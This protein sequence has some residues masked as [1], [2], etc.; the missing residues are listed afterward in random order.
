MRYTESMQCPLHDG[1][2]I[3][4][5]AQGE[6]GLT[7]SY[8]TCP[9][10]RGYWMDS[11]A[12]NFIKL[13]NVDGTATITTASTYYCPVCTK[14]LIWTTGE[15]IPDGVCVY[16]CPVH[17]G[18][19]FPTGQLAAFKKAQQTKIEYHK[20]WHIPMPNVASILLGGLVLILLSGGLAVTLRGLE[21][22]QTMESQAKQILVNHAVYSTADHT[23]ILITATTGLDA[24]A[25]VHVPALNNLT[26]P[27]QSGDHRTH[28]L[29]IQ[30]VPV[31]TYRYF[32]TIEVSG[33]E[34]LSDTFTFTVLDQ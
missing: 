14:P 19:F 20:L 32:F 26:A 16:D 3:S 21:Q 9:V 23:T 11:F 4:H 7:V 27:M 13:N 1:E 6:N 15:N 18:Y 10:C 22:R 31:G 33:K 30:N 8:S 2:L 17:H 12:A 25:T 29:T 24:L 28:Q 5:T 34:T